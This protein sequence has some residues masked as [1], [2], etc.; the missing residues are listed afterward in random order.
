M[1]RFFNQILH[2]ASGE[3][4]IE[5]RKNAIYMQFKSSSFT[6]EW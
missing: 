4:G 2:I 3:N 5:Y 1:Q 6:N